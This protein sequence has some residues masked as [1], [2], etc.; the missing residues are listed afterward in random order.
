MFRLLLI[1]SLTL[2]TFSCLFA[3]LE[4]KVDW[5]KANKIRPGA[6][7]VHLSYPEPLLEA[8]LMRIDLKTPGIRFHA[9]KPSPRW[10]EPLPG[11]K[12]KTITTEVCKTAD[13]LLDLHRKHGGKKVKSGRRIDFAVA[14]NSMPWSPFPCS[15]RFAQ[16]SGPAVSAGKFIGI[17]R[18]GPAVFIVYNDGRAVITG[19]F[20]EKNVSNVAVAATGFGLLLDAKGD[21]LKSYHPSRHPR[22]AF[23]LSKNGRYLYILTVDGRQQ[24]YS[25]GAT[26]KDLAEILRSVGAY[27]AMNMDG[28]GST[29][30]CYRKSGSDEI[31]TISHCVSRKKGVARRVAFNI[32]ISFEE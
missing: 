8:D 23:G 24:G 32:A 22:T 5:N 7:H 21:F 15:N 10:G 16:V 27:S 30:L 26:L 12:N 14:V 13:F 9:T 4:A 1:I 18:G 19:S 3:G 20:T 31:E 2:S 17:R 6:L 28:G 11:Y 29:T 25:I